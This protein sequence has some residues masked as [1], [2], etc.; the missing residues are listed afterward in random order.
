MPPILLARPDGWLLEDAPSAW[1]RPP[2]PHPSVSLLAW[3][4]TV[5]AWSAGYVA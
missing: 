1:P 4:R 5:R 2:D 3:G